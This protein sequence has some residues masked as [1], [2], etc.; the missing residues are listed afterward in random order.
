[1][2]Y[3]LQDNQDR[4]LLEMEFSVHLP[5]WRRLLV[6][7]GGIL[8]RL[9]DFAW[10]V[11]WLWLCSGWQL[12][13]PNSFPSLGLYP[14]A[15]FVAFWSSRCS[16]IGGLFACIL[17]G[18]LVDAGAFLTLGSHA[19]ALIPVALLAT[20]LEDWLPSW[21]FTVLNPIIQGFGASLLFGV[22]FLLFCGGDSD[23]LFRLRQFGRHVLPSALVAGLFVA[24]LLFALWE[25]V[26]F[27]GR[28]RQ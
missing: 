7:H 25:L 28:Q 16:L 5:A 18:W 15:L 9:A 20:C 4:R 12:A 2:K 26:P 14:L 24:P 10:Y 6:G 19:L 21:K 17:G 1:M 13:W 8:S 27:F 3:T 23:A 22:C 11:L